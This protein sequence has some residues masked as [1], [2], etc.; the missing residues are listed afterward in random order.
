MTMATN[1]TDIIENAIRDGAELVEWAE[2]NTAALA[3]DDTEYA[4]LAALGG[5]LA[6]EL[7]FGVPLLR[8]ANLDLPAVPLIQAVMSPPKHRATDCDRCRNPI[9]R[10]MRSYDLW[11]PMGASVVAVTTCGYCHDVLNDVTACDLVWR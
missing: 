11:V 2:P 1:P 6:P 3:D 9:G 10:G 4:A 7:A 8:F 5:P